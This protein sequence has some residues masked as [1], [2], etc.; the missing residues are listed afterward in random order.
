MGAAFW[1]F[2]DLSSFP[3]VA[4]AED[5]YQTEHRSALRFPYQP[6]YPHSRTFAL[7]LPVITDSYFI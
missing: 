1:C 4:F 6:E 7:N 5:S 3:T 2:I